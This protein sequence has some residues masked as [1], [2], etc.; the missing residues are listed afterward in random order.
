M[1]DRQTTGHLHALVTQH[2][3]D[4]APAALVAAAALAS[5]WDIDVNLLHA[6]R[7]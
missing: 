1:E 7:Y 5:S 3:Q 4:E 2:V 6:M